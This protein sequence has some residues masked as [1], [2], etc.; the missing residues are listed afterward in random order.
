MALDNGDNEGIGE[1]GTFSIGST[2]IKFTSVDFAN[3]TILTQKGNV[4]KL[5]IPYDDVSTVRIT[6][7][8]G[9]VVSSFSTN[10]NSFWYTIPGNISS[11]IHFVTIKAQKGSIVK[12]FR[13]VR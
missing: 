6:N 7:V 4:R 3:K 5:Y 10:P 9:K 2:G 12:Q 1:S 11:G 8:Q 13:F